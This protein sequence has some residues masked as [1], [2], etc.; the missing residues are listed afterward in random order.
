MVGIKKISKFIKLQSLN[1]QHSLGLFV[2]LLHHLLNVRLVIPSCP[3]RS[4]GFGAQASTARP[5]LHLDYIRASLIRPAQTLAVLPAHLLQQLVAHIS[6]ADRCLCHT[7]GC[8]GESSSG[9]LL[10][11]LLLEALSTLVQR[12]G[13]RFAV[14]L[15]SFLRTVTVPGERERG[16]GE[17]VICNRPLSSFI[18]T[19]DSAS[20]AEPPSAPFAALYLARFCL[21]RSDILMCF[22]RISSLWNA[23]WHK[24]HV[25]FLKST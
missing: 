6:A 21:C 18:V 13:I 4:S 24:R 2:P 25:N 22:F 7:G 15:A 5:T 11:N 3:R 8:S 1:A 23:R 19:H 12:Y 14:F 20:A 17:L 9:C 10:L 16:I